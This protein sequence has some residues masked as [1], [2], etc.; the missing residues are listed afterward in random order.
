MRH[1]FPCDDLWE[2]TGRVCPCFICAGALQESPGVQQ[3]GCGTGDE[4]TS[5]TFLGGGGSLLQRTFPPPLL[6]SCRTSCWRAQVALAGQKLGWGGGNGLLLPYK[7]DFLPKIGEGELQSHSLFPNSI[8]VEVNGFAQGLQSAP[9]CWNGVGA[10]LLLA[11]RELIG[12]IL[13]NLNA[14]RAPSCFSSIWSGRFT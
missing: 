13:A 5:W 2:V 11:V 1:F 4:V 6:L 10:V 3:H 12:S 14:S 9:E 7:H 8:S